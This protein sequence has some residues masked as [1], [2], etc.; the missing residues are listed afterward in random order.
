MSDSGESSTASLCGQ[1]DDIMVAGEDNIS[2]NL[3]SFINTLDPSITSDRYGLQHQEYDLRHISNDV[4]RQSTSA[5]NNGPDS[6]IDMNDN[7]EISENNL[8]LT[9]ESDGE[10]ITSARRCN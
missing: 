7:I 5:A 2:D 10:K 3:E 9:I 6:R 1:F 4:I 8:S